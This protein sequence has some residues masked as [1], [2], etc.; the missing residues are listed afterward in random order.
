[1]IPANGASRSLVKPTPLEKEAMQPTPAIRLENLSKTFG[2]GR[3][4]VQAV[5]NVDLEVQAGQVYGFL[6]PNG[7]GKTTTIR[8]LMNLIR[9]TQGTAWI[10][11][12]DVRRNPSVLK[13]VGALVEGAA[14][15]G[16]MNGRDNLA[17]LART[18]NDYRRERIESLLEQMGLLERAGQPV[19]KYSLGMK[20][21]LGIAAALLNDPE[22]VILDEP[23]NGLDP[24]GIQE[25]R[26]FIR[27]L[28]KQQGKTVFLSSHLLHEVEQ[29]CDRVAIIYKGAIVREGIVSELLAGGEAELR[30]QATP[31]R[32]AAAVIKDAWPVSVNRSWLTVAAQPKESPQIVRLLV[33]QDVEVHQVIIRH[34]SLEEYFI[35]VTHVEARNGEAAHA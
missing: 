24:S 23:T 8:M 4:I 7:A 30:V 33:S 14:F 28:A 18:A 12:Q 3:D 31:L 27:D 5:K 13:R 16:Y 6:G 22:L 11:D 10:F 9:P 19:S 21:R 35:D 34:P 29:V 2:R 26:S 20:Q 32:R 25:M 15:Y 17:V 1:M